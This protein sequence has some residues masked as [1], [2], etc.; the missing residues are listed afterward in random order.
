L[1]GERGVNIEK[2]IDILFE[3]LPEGPALYPTDIISDAPKKLVIADIIRE[4][5]LQTL[6]Q[7]V[8]Y[9]LGVTIEE[10]RPVRKKTTHIKALILVERDS[11]KEIVIGKKGAMLQ[12]VGTLARKELEELLETKVFLECFVKTHKN[13]RDDVT[14]LQELDHNQ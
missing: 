9:S 11:Q 4:K 7:E 14:L 3:N 1:S 10:I 2:L 12:R 5:F 13:W 6:R 8:P